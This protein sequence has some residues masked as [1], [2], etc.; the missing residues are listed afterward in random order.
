MIGSLDHDDSIAALRIPVQ[1]MGVDYTDAALEAI[2]TYIAV[3]S[4]EPNPYDSRGEILMAAD[5]LD[6]AI[7]S[8]HEALSVAPDFPGSLPPMVRA[9][10]FKGNRESAD[11]CVQI[12][13]KHTSPMLRSIGRMDAAILLMSAGK[14]R[15]A[16]ECIDHGVGADL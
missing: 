5:R 13:T 2:N 15:A 9:Y 12:M 3:V 10:L 4:D 7:A 6:A 1:E 14:M 11:S 8:Y 16:L